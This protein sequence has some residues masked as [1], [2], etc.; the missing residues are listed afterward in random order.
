VRRLDPLLEE[1]TVAAVAVGALG[2]AVAVI[3]RLLTGISPWPFLVLGEVAGLGLG[4]VL[5]ALASP[6]RGG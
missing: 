6:R 4:I 1:V 5:L 3:F 2:V